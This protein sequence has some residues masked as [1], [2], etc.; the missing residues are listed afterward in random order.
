MD[1]A[2]VGTLAD[3]HLGATVLVG[4]GDLDLG[5]PYQLSGPGI[6]GTTVRHLPAGDLWRFSRERTN[7]EFPL[8]VDLVFFD[9]KGQATALPRTTRITAGGEV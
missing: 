1:Q 4:T 9:L 3:P 6:D 7:A 8:G 2:P 5:V